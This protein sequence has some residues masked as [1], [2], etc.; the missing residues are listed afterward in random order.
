[1]T[2]HVDTHTGTLEVKLRAA[3]GFN[4]R[5]PTFCML[6][7]PFS[8]DPDCLILFFHQRPDDTLKSE[9]RKRDSLASDPTCFGVA[10]W[11]S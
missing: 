10:K 2:R 3:L 5:E 11:V 1:M 7:V 6:M 8:G 9:T 4:A